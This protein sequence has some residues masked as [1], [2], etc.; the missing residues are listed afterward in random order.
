MKPA[1]A[2]RAAAGILAAG[3]VLVLLASGPGTRFGAWHWGVGL[4]M[5]RW[6]VYLGGAAGVLA[7][8]GL[9][10]PRVR[11]GHA[12]LLAL[13]LVAGLASAAVPLRF[14]QLARSVPPIHEIATDPGDPPPFVAVLALRATA[15]NPPHYGGEKV[16]SQQLAAYPDIQPL[17]LALPVKE[18]F[19]RAHRVAQALG[20]DVVA[21][22]AAAGRIEATHTTAWFGFKDDVVVR[23][24]PAGT[25]G[26]RIDVRSKSRVGRGDAG[27]NAKR[28]RSFLAA[29]RQSG[30]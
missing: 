22:D 2:L 17:V 6:S 9:A 5:L 21:I 27:A 25:S 13:A 12:G 20:W 23:V 1:A 15:P 26:S 24:L 30:T 29:L 18:A 14:Q 3:A 11:R 19:E 16:A 7:L 8:A 4:G 10:L 28:V